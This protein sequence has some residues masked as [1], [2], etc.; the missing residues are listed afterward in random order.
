M[1]RK[2]VV[3]S[4]ETERTNKRDEPEGKISE[5]ST[6]G[7]KTVSE[8]EK[9]PSSSRKPQAM[10]APDASEAIDVFDPNSDAYIGQIPNH[11]PRSVKRSKWGL[12]FIACITAL[13]SLGIGLWFMQMIE[14]LFA[15]NQWIGWAASTLLAIATLSL[16]IILLRE[17]F[18][19]WRLRT[20]G[21]IREDVVRALQD[22]A[23]SSRQLLDQ[24]VS[25]YD[26]RKEMHWHISRLAEH[27]NDVMD[28]DDRLLLTERSLMKPLDEEAKQIIA[29]AA[30]QVS[31][32]TA[33]NPAP[34]L[35]VLFTGYQILKMLRRLT[36]LYGSRPGSIGT[37]RLAKMVGSHLAITGGLA[38]SDTLIQQFIG[39][40][41]AGR[42]SA[43]LGEGTVNGILTARIG[44]AALDLC[45][46]MPFTALEKPGLKEF[47]A[48]IAGS[49]N[50]N[51]TDNQETS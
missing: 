50:G 16:F 3:V 31:V 49:L 14:T 34:S 13:I 10:N 11:V 45:R 51:S 44:L 33:I 47:L 46:P 20:L 17:V 6:R 37:L 8:K 23:N 42:L 1:S 28:S 41:L 30:K 39:K 12:L 43:K 19:L 24:I 29:A 18:A 9:E 27:T 26:D 32:V 5:K 4:L 22:D 40:G 25:L 48:T 7:S 38:L 2:P 36:A 15:R 21:R 35:D